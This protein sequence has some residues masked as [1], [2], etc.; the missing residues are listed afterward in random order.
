LVRPRKLSHRHE[1]RCRSGPPSAP[2]QTALEKIWFWAVV[3]AGRAG[4][5]PT[6]RAGRWPPGM[7]TITCTRKLSRSGTRMCHPG[8]GLTADLG[9]PFSSEPPPQR[10][11]HINSVRA[12]VPHVPS[13]Q[14]SVVVLT[15]ADPPISKLEPQHP[16]PLPPKHHRHE[17]KFVFL[18][19]H[20]SF[21]GLPGSPN[22]IRALR[23]AH[24]GGCYQQPPSA[25]LKPTPTVPGAPAHPPCPPM[26]SKDDTPVPA[27]SCSLS[28]LL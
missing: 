10:N 3:G 8:G 27:V 2:H 6:A 1:R 17:S 23:T 7:H 21:T 22:R 25:A 20:S 19:L 24:Q 5:Y 11:P 28:S 12:T 15:T 16:P 26:L 13:V 14:P 4:R 9:T 18:H